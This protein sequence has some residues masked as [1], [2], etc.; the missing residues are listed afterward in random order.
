M[1]TENLTTILSLS[2]LTMDY[3]LRSMDFYDDD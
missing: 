1:N 2:S 3:G